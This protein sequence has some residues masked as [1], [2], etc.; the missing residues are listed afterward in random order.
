MTILELIRKNRSYRR[1]DQSYEIYKNEML[2]LVELARLSPS[3][4]NLQPLKFKMVYKSDEC[5]SIFP[6]LG[7]AGYLKEWAGPEDGERPSGYIVVAYDTTLTDNI[8]CDEGLAMQSILLGAVEMG[9]GG[10]I[11]GSCNRE[12]IQEILNID[13][14]YSICYVI[15]LGKPI[16]NVVVDEVVEDDIKYW[17]SEDGTHHVPKRRL[18]DILL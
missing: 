17:R 1:F 4:R 2:Q 5:N 12:K 14:R 7:W 10:C 9:L 8:F 16:E 18:E 3:A 13:S 11:I 15:A 6:Y